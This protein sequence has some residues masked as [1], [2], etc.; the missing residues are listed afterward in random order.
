MQ[1][2]GL[3]ILDIA[4]IGGY[5]ILMLVIGKLLARG[6]KVQD[7][8]YLAGRKLG[9]VLQF[10]LHF[11][12]MTDA[13]GAPSVASEIYRRGMSGAWLNLQYLFITPF[14]WF[15]KVWWR[16]SRVVTLSDMFNERFGGKGCGSLYAVYA[17]LLSIMCIG[18]GNLAAYKTLAA[19]VVKPETSYTQQEAQGVTDF[20][21]YKELQ[22]MQQ[23]GLL[24]PETQKEYQRLSD[25]QAQG[26]LYAFVTYLKSPMIFYVIYSVIVGIYMI[27]GGFMAAVITDT[28]QGIL[29]VVFSCIMIPFGL[30]KLGGISGLGQAVPDDMLQIFGTV[31]S[32]EYT[33]YSI[34]M[35]ILATLVGYYGAAQ[36][37]ITGGSAKN[38]LAARLGAV[39]GGFAKRLMI[40]AWILCGLIGL[41]LYGGEIADPDM[42]W[43]VL[44]RALLGPGLLGLMLAGILAAN[45]ST[46]D[47]G[48]ITSSSLFVRNIYM[49]IIPGH[50]ESHYVLVGRIAAGAI[51]FLGV[52]V[53]YISSGLI[54]LFKVLITLP[55]A[56]G[57]VAL[58]SVFWR[59]LTKCAVMVQVV[60]M[61]VIVGLVPYIFG[62]IPGFR[63]LPGLTVQ[64]IPQTVEIKQLNPQGQ[65]INT[66]FTTEPVG[67]FF[68]SVVH[69]NPNDPESPLVGLGR[70]S[71]EIYLCSW[72]GFSVEKYSKAGLV[73]LRF[74]F[75]AFAPFILLFVISA[76]TK[77][78]KNELLDKFYVKLKTPIA[79]S[80]EEDQK[81]VDYS[82]ANPHRFDHFKLFPH[83]N[84]EI[85]KWTKL[86]ALGFV[87][88]WLAVGF[89]MLCLWVVLYMA[90]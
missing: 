27:L 24:S 32:S 46:I 38:E 14:F 60:I 81:Q 44:S 22:K 50:N 51:L 52:M 63:S 39:T 13:S 9:K 6:V 17:I 83:S 3:H 88:C 77:S 89:V 37:M 41:G 61:I 26:K 40:V 69:E 55:T 31:T 21:R 74:G 79:S 35:I 54:P 86:D 25:F 18:F 43:G 5:L 36:E 78:G 80:A 48:M 45:M 4:I 23:K 59:R 68:E 49:P 10:F 56:F 47:A 57:A 15:S 66:Q 1:L 53:A 28:V 75:C 72:L 76:F 84:W 34:L 7:D 71:P 87:F 8:F 62:A 42:T 64:T 90:R 11:G 58:L 82:M 70:F 67:V 2:F 30:I 16:R 19:L 12:A 33:W 29:I 65:M 20:Y 85:C 73:A